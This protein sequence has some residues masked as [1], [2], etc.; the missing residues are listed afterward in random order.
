MSRVWREFTGESLLRM[1]DFATSGYYISGAFKLIELFIPLLVFKILIPVIQRAI[2]F[3]INI[4]TF[5]PI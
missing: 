4:V 3:V 2:T 5:L 1:Q